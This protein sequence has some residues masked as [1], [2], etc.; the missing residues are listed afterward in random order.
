M[1]TLAIT[2][3]FEAVS[4]YNT[5]DSQQDGPSV[6]AAAECQYV[7]VVSIGLRIL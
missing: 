5:I 7:L 3:T 1:G 4:D 6:E 2:F